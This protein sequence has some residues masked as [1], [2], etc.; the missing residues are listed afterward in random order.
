[1]FLHN[2]KYSLKTLLK[3]KMLVF[4]NIAFPIIL[5]ILFNMA[6]SNIESDERLDIIDIAVVDNDAFKGNTIFK[7]ALEGLSDKESDD[8]MFDIV[9]V[10]ADEIEAR[11]LLDR[12]DITG[13]LTF[14]KDDVNITV[15]SNGI[16]ETILRFVVDEIASNKEMVES[17][18]ASQLEKEMTEK[19]EDIDISAIYEKALELVQEKRSNIKDV[20]RDNLSYTMIEYYTL[21]A[22][23]CLYGGTFSMFIVNYKLANMHSVGKRITVS[24]AKKG[25]MLLGSLCASYVVQLIGLALLFIFTVFVIKVDYGNNLPLIILLACCGSLAGLSLGVA[26]ATLVK[27]SENA[28]TGILISITMGGCFLSGM[29]GITMKYVVDKNLPFINKINPASMITDGFY[30]LYYYDTLDRFMIDIVSLLVF[31]AI[32][33]FISYNGLRRQRYDSI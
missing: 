19:K 33:I 27:K 20:S 21:I 28:K 12:G 30:A 6:F 4:W 15:S 14:E 25:A 32:M 3:A 29:M 23:A 17:I 31:S 9:Y 22:M 2:F 26:V 1:M 7:E 16:N 8:R 18:A 5:G 24:P 13:Y 11:K 10:N